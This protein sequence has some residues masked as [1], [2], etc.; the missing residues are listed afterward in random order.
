MRAFGVVGPKNLA[1][2]DEEV[3]Q[4]AGAKRCLDRGGPVAFTK[5]L[6]AHMRVRYALLPFC[7]IRLLGLHVIDARPPDLFPVQYD[8]KWPEIDVLQRDGRSEHRD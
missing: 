4:A 3:V 1:D 8:P 2:E 5:L 7:A 6:I